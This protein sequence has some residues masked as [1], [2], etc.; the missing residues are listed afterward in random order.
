MTLINISF[1]V[2]M[3]R[4]ATSAPI[5]NSGYSVTSH[6]PNAMPYSSTCCPTVLYGRTINS[7]HCTK[8]SRRVEVLIEL[9]LASKRSIAVVA[10]VRW[11]VGRQIEVLL[12]GLLTA[13]RPVAN[14]P[15]FTQLI[16]YWR[17]PWGAGVLLSGNSRRNSRACQW[18][19]CHQCNDAALQSSIETQR[20]VLSSRNR[21]GAREKSVC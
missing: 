13:E 14:A 9:L 5:P 6:P 3:P 19:R 18:S 17:W 7:D 21:P 15:F 4:A 10:F 12:E 11:S 8:V 20:I 2:P 16:G 1:P